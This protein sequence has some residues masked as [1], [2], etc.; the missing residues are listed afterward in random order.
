MSSAY[1]NS[2]FTYI[3]ET[4]RVTYSVTRLL[5]LGCVQTQVCVRFA[6]VASRAPSL[7]FPSL[8]DPTPLIVTCATSGLFS[9]L[10]FIPDHHPKPRLHR[11]LYHTL[12]LPLPPYLPHQLHPFTITHSL[13]LHTHRHILLILG[14]LVAT[15]VLVSFKYIYCLCPYTGYHDNIGT[16]Q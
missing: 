8:P 5:L 12:S 1:I 3:T 7:S 10:F 6:G 2:Q 4:L 15:F 11:I 13:H 9:G 16:Y 14:L